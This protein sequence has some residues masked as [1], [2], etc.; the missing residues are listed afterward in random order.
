MQMHMPAQIL[1]PGVQ[2]QRERRFAA[3]VAWIGRELGQRFGDGGEQALV[4]TPRMST[5]QVVERMRHGEYKM[6]VRYRQQFLSPRP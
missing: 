6:E 2:D 4:E 3:Q 5:H 1:L